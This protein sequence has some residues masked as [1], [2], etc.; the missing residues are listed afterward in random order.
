MNLNASLSAPRLLGD[1]GGTNARFALVMGNGSTIT[2]EVTLPSGQRTRLG[3]KRCG[4][5]RSAR[6]HVPPAG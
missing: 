1:I 2:H 5:R 3:R 6:M 4:L